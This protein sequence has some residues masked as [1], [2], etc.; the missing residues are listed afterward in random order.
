[1]GVQLSLKAVL[2]LAEILA[3]V[4]SRCS[5]TGPRLPY[6]HHYPVVPISHLITIPINSLIPS[7][8]LRQNPSQTVC[9]PSILLE[10]KHPIQFVQRPQLVRRLLARYTDIKHKSLRNKDIDYHAPRRKQSW[11]SYTVS[12]RHILQTINSAIKWSNCTNI[13][14]IM[15]H[16][17][18]VVTHHL[19]PFSIP[20]MPLLIGVMFVH[21]QQLVN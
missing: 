16:G 9:T 17:L 7:N 12:I 18:N 8:D 2:P 14:F 10:F 5:N 21:W 3:T 11:L 20:Q 13:G 15:G 19:G 1:M 4:S 6:W